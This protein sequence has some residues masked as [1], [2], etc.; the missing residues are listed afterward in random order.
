MP[1][2]PKPAFNKQAFDDLTLA[3][4]IEQLLEVQFVKGYVPLRKSK[5]ES[6]SLPCMQPCGIYKPVIAQI[7]TWLVDVGLAVQPAPGMYCLK[8]HCLGRRPYVPTRFL[9][10]QHAVVCPFPSLHI[11]W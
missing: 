10:E 5:Q 9:V 4:V 1:R 8:L 2:S 3:V 11:I 6:L 7:L